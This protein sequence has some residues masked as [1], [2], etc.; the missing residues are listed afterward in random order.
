MGVTFSA[1]L[2]NV[3]FLPMCLINFKNF[4]QLRSLTA[5][6]SFESLQICH[7]RHLC[8]LPQSDHANL[9][10]MARDLYQQNPTKYSILKPPNN[11][12]P[13][14]K[15]EKT[16]KDA[17][18]IA[19]IN[20]WIDIHEIASNFG[21]PELLDQE[22]LISCLEQI[23]QWPLLSVQQSDTLQYIINSLDKT[24]Y[25]NFDTTDE[26]RK[27]RIGFLWCLSLP[28][29]KQPLFLP[30]FIR[31]EFSHT[32]STDDDDMADVSKWKTLPTVYLLLAAFN[33]QRID[34]TK[35]IE[36][37]FHFTNENF[38]N[39]T[40]TELA[41]CFAGLS[42]ALQKEEIA[43]INELRDRITSRYG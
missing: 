20:D 16:N 13:F 3:T 19:L 40:V 34:N 36:K 30:F 38:A 28:K 18:K 9:C 41:V 22:E 31:Q 6:T 42:A 26:L 27:Q 15:L 32:T 7:H 12:N 21:I 11:Y 43:A 33:N 2:R 14:K 10:G 25:K 23:H 37:L 17:K 1:F 29:L 8:Q 35:L 5:L 24:C 4:S 39:L